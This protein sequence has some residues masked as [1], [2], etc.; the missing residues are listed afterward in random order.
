MTILS[1]FSVFRLP[2]RRE[3]AY[4][5]L[6]TWIDKWIVRAPATS[7]KTL[8]WSAQILGSLR[9]YQAR[10]E[11]RLASPEVPGAGG[12][13]RHSDAADCFMTTDV[14]GPETN[15]NV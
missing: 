12:L 13:R 9:S 7:T 10:E 8:D 1:S 2:G 3:S 11:E 5:L 14:A 6:V 4:A 15:S